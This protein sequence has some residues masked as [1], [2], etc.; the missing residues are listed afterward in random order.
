[1]GNG[2]HAP[3]ANDG[4]HGHPAH[5]WCA[6]HQWS[7]KWRARMGWR[8]KSC[9]GT[10]FVQPLQRPWNPIFNFNWDEHPSGLPLHCEF[11]ARRSNLAGGEQH[12]PILH[13]HRIST[14]RVAHRDFLSSIFR[15]HAGLP[16]ESS[17]RPGVW[18]RLHSRRES[19]NS[20]HH[21]TE[22]SKR[23]IRHAFLCYGT[24]ILRMWALSL[25]LDAAPDFRLKPWTKHIWRVQMGF[26]VLIF[27]SAGTEI[28]AVGGVSACTKFLQHSKLRSFMNSIIIVN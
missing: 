14:N 27:G 5:T 23:A 3:K 9:A 12:A 6:H 13:V 15:R 11:A 24:L 26:W 17:W 20:D 2:G 21:R 8:H 28:A 10:Q 4:G 22:S 25:N 7:W 19:N 1:M 18:R 16:Q